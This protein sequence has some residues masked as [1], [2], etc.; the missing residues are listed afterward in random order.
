MGNRLRHRRAK[1]AGK[2]RGASPVLQYFGRTFQITQE[3]PPPQGMPV[4]NY[5]EGRRG[6]W[7]GGGD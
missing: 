6:G 1:Y 5:L 4:L 3:P 7:M 2:P